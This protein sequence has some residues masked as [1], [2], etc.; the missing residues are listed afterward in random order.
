M[1]TAY[2]RSRVARLREPIGPTALADTRKEVWQEKAKLETSGGRVSSHAK[3]PTILSETHT[4]A[5]QPRQTSEK[6][7]SKGGRSG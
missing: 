7:Q 4:Q 1:K 6:S 3:P 5:T 2:V